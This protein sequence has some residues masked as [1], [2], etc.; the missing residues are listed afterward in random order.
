MRK[1]NPASLRRLLLDAYDAGKRH[2]PWRGESDPYRIWVSEVM[3][4]QTRAETVVPYYGRWLERFPDIHTLAEA[5]EDEV[6]R[7]WQGLGYYSRARRLHQGARLLRER[8]SGVLPTSSEALR[9]LPGVGVY[10]AGAIAS[11][12][13]GEAVPAVDGNVKRVLSR[14]FDLP[15]PSG[16]ELQSVAG[17]L[18]DPDRPGDFN[19]ALMELGALVCLP[20][21]ARCESCPLESECLAL[22]RGTV[23]ERPVTKLKKPVPETEVDVLVAVAWDEAGQ[24]H[25]LLRKRPATGLL[26]GMWEF[27]GMEGVA[28]TQIGPDLIELDVVPHT[29]SHLKIRYRPFLLQAA[30]PLASAPGLESSHWVP[31]AELDSVPLPVAQGKIAAMALGVLGAGEYLG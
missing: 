1:K 21:S 22:R 12:A 17:E 26:A 31:V 13:Y 27:P 24:L 2:L 4:Q 28:K 9:E 10:T 11:I 29:F 14:L 23:S 7:A 30:L 19:Q 5:E 16:A 25:F 3:L 6:L 15:D 8:Y 20:R 18:L